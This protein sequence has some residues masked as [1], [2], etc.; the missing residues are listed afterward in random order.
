VEHFLTTIGV[1]DETMTEM[2]GTPP[3]TAMK[4]VA[5]TLVYDS[6]ISEATSYRLLASV[7]VPTLILSSESSSDDLMTMSTTVATAMPNASHRSIA[8]EWHGTPDNILAD[9]LNEFFR[10]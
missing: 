3:W 5:H 6:L 8:G 7:T 2:R 9:A 4:T 10:S 1:P